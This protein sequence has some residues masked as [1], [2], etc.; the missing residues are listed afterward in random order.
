MDLNVVRS[1]YESDFA[2]IHISGPFSVFVPVSK[3]V[4]LRA[5]VYTVQYACMSVWDRVCE[6]VA[7]CCRCQGF[8]SARLAVPTVTL[9]FLYPLI[10]SFTSFSVWLYL[11]TRNSEEHKTMES[12]ES[13][14]YWRRIRHMKVVMFY[15][16]VAFGQETNISGLFP[17]QELQ[18]ED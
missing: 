8:G 6:T 5:Q 7:L 12:R 17:Q 16:G 11:S 18:Y 1:R 10:H 9:F 4:C 14:M 13:D 15:P 3:L 2:N